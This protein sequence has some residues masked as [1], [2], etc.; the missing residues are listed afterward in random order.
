M[1]EEA[2]DELKFSVVRV[3]VLFEDLVR[4]IELLLKSTSPEVATVAVDGIGSVGTGTG[5]VD[6]I[7]IVKIECDFYQDLVR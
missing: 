6:K 5:E 1:T 3:K 4:L 2:V 7:S